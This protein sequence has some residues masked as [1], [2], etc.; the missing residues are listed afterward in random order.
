M[1]QQHGLARQIAGEQ[2]PGQG[3]AAAEALIADRHAGSQAEGLGAAGIQGLRAVVAAELGVVVA[4]QSIGQPARFVE[5]G[6]VDGGRA[7]MDGSPLVWPV[8]A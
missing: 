2:L 1:G 5:S 6:V 3:H 4:D 7:A 8:G